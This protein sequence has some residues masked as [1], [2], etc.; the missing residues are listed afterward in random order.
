MNRPVTPKPG[1][2]VHPP[3]A[4]A[5]SLAS[6]DSTVEHAGTGPALQDDLRR[7]WAAGDCVRAEAY[8]EWHPGL[9]DEAAIDLI[10]GE[11]LVRSER[12]DGPTVEEY[13]ARF[14]QYAARL[15]F[16]LAFDEVVCDLI[17]SNSV[18]VAHQDGAAAPILEEAPGRIGGKYRIIEMLDRGGQ[19]EVYR[20][21]HE[22]LRRDV[23]IKL[24]RRP[25]PADSAARS[26]FLAEGRILAGLQHPN[27]AAVYDLDFHEDRAY[28]AIEFVRGQTLDQ[29]ARGRRLSPLK[30]AALIAQAARAV[31][32]AHRCGVIHRDIK[33]KNIL[34]DEQGTPRV[35]DFG[36]ARLQDAWSVGRADEENISGTLPF[37][38]PEQAC[39]NG[40]PADAR[41][42]VFALGAVLYY[43]LTGR[44][45]YGGNGL[46]E[47]LT[48]ARTCAYDRTALDRPAIPPR[49]RAI[50][51]KAMAPEPPDRYAGA[52]E[53]AAALEGL[54]RRSRP[55][56]WL[57]GLI[58][59]ALLLALAAAGRHWMAA[60]PTVPESA[61]PTLLVR[62]AEDEEDG[63]KSL[64]D[65]P[66]P[67]T[68]SLMMIEVKVP[69]RVSAALF[70][71][72]E[73]GEV[74][75]LAARPADSATPIRVPSEATALQLKG[76]KET[77]EMLLVVGTTG[78]GGVEDDKVRR[79]FA[80]LPFPLHGLPR[81][82]YLRVTRGKTEWE[83]PSRDFGAVK[84]IPGAEVRQSIDRVREALRE[85]FDYVE[86][87]V[88]THRE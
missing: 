9:D 6:P 37:M 17:R 57:S 39:E 71:V 44:A 49:L 46:A 88:F 47:V 81:N 60:A 68:G 51:L 74:N 23:I 7:R 84:A 52:D 14:P 82:Q 27:I 59:C 72:N 3:G 35:I 65:R 21:L 50:C 45:P 70:H 69:E 67:A 15:Q 18:T 16:L 73:R 29:Y 12:G 66:A 34:V 24:S 55:A 85:D 80:G 36:L 54:Q 61:A 79:A 56:L 20:A 53:L 86:G 78:R 30:A 33:P 5:D 77:T 2:S 8:L 64:A 87:V 28:L 62:V 1:T 42:D 11:F 26:S 48:Q 58:G 40:P 19:G 25:C 38:P 83:P 41:T 10:Y 32:A 75:R 76:K 22:T 63:F 4:A 13:L 31:A 43:L